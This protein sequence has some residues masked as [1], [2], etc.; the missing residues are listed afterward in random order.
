MVETLQTPVAVRPE[1]EPDAITFNKWSPTPP[2]A[3]QPRR[4]RPTRPATDPTPTAPNT[5]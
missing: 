1:P 5:T 4:Q 2:A 3:N